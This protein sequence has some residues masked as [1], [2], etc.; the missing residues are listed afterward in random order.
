MLRVS[1][2][3]G[4]KFA[5][6]YLKPDVQTEK[7]TKRF[8]NELDFCTR[9][10]HRN[11]I[12]VEDH[13]RAEIAGVEVPF[14]IMQVFPKTLR[15]LIKAKTSPDK[16]LLLFADIINGIEHA[17]SR[18]IWHRDIK[19]ENI[20]IT[21]SEDRAVVTDFGIAHFDDEYL[22]TIVDTMPSE[23]LANFRYAAPEQRGKEA[24]DQ[25]ADIYALG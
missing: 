9:N 17:H 1:D 25:R 21:N 14:F 18:E 11:I 15:T 19:P 6:K 8:K 3:N 13:G 5:L 7:K 24:V 22:H 10:T 23:R 12:T 16:L 4:D 2:Q 20:L